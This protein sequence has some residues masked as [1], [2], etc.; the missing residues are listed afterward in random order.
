MVRQLAA[1]IDAWSKMVSL[2]CPQ[3]VTAAGLPMGKLN[4]QWFR[5]PWFESGG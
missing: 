1:G 3:T 2:L 4:P 5:F